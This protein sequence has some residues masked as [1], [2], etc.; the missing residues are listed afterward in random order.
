MYL[1]SVSNHIDADHLSVYLNK[2]YF[3]N[4]NHPPNTQ[5]R[6]Q[7]RMTSFSFV[8]DESPPSALRYQ[9]LR[10]QITI[11]FAVEFLD[12][13][14]WDLPAFNDKPPIKVHRRICDVVNCPGKTGET[15]MQVLE[16]QWERLGLSKYDC[17]AGTGDGGG[18]N[19]GTSGV[20]SLLE[21]TVPDYV[22]RR[23]LS[24]L[25]W[26][27]ADQVLAALGDDHRKTKAIASYL[28]EGGTWNR[29]KA[30]A[31]TPL[32]D[33]G[34]GLFRDA[35]PEYAMVF[36]TGSPTNIDERPDTTCAVLQW[37]N[38]RHVVLAK[39]AAHDITTRNMAGSYNNLARES[40]TS[41]TDHVTRRITYVILKKC[42]FM[43]YYIEGKEHVARH[44]GMDELFERAGQIIVST[45]PDHHVLGFLGLTA[46]ELRAA[47]MTSQTHW[48]EVAVR[49]AEGL[50]D[51]EKDGLLAPVI[52]L[53]DKL[54]L[55][56]H[57]HLLLTSKNVLRSTWSAARV[58]ATNAG[59]AQI[60][61]NALLW[62]PSVGL[63]RL[64]PDQLTDFENALLNNEAVF[65]QLQ[66][67]AARAEPVR[68]W[69]ADGK[70]AALFVFLA[71]RFCGAPDHVLDAE[72][73][74][75]Q[76][77][78]LQGGRHAIKFKMLNAVLK[79]RH[80]HFTHGKIPAFEAMVDY[81]DH[82]S[83]SRAA[84]YAALVTAGDVAV[85][86][87]HDQPYR[88]RF[89]LRGMDAAMLRAI[90][91]DDGA[92]ESGPDKSVDVQFANYCR[93]LFE[94]HHL[95]QFANLAGPTKFVYITE[96]KSIQYR[97][98]PKADQAIGR[99]IC[100]VFYEPIAD[101]IEID[102]YVSPDEVVIVPCAGDR[103]QLNIQQMTL[104]EM[105]LA[106][107][108][109][110]TDIGPNFSER[111]VE[112]LHESRV[113]NHGIVHIESRR[114]LAGGWVRIAK[115]SSAIDIEQHA[116]ATR[117]AEGYDGLT[118]MALARAL[119]RRDGFSD[120]VRERILNLNWTTLKDAI[121]A[122]PVAIVALAKAI[123][124]AP[125]VAKAA[126][127]VVAKAAAKV[128]AKPKAKVVAKPKAKG[129]AKAKPKI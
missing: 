61:A 116:F 16:K 7:G 93:F 26:R 122:K 99:H 50:T 39:L 13:S 28:H 78:Y 68:V 2:M 4:P 64:R 89:N 62:A 54:V 48:A 52:A 22:R 84:R 108:Y 36:G 100:L 29:F 97:D 74:H 6:D 105:C 76:W 33:G 18:E 104:A 15:V 113:L 24:H 8:S 57:S 32:D 46:P 94:P 91:A 106:A 69:Q 30:I 95:Y 102:E 126:A 37:V 63:M 129:A 111:D 90:G 82:V 115:P 55:R 66:H 12:R 44:V 10:F 60:A 96:N 125:V 72:S 51:A 38:E 123:A 47:G 75:A 79:L 103:L 20:H 25:P 98:K 17:V 118:K 35:S 70:Y 81:L 121:E 92:D 128:V 80:Y 83:A 19:E 56:A 110:P 112:K 119:Q 86:F 59:A 41:K 71:D 31:V 34:L 9:A 1:T 21:R 120:I 117:T 77:Q 11:I 124:P 101:D 49:T 88:E 14:T 127:K 23:C 87:V 3:N 40:L 109:Y 107:G 43:Y 5:A 67:F 27:V 73:V 85:N 53:C 42:L 45:K 114:H 65:A 58:L